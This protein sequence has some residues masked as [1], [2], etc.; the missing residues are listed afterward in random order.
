M[1]YYVEPLSKQVLYLN[2]Y[3][4]VKQGQV[5]CCCFFK[6]QSPFALGKTFF[7]LNPLTIKRKFG[8]TKLE[9][10]AKAV[11]YNMTDS[12]EYVV[13]VCVGDG[14]VGGESRKKCDRWSWKA[15]VS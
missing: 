15:L 6:T 11:L 10:V 12:R 3:Y 14:G 5:L 1:F 2:K 7:F 8:Q 4:F 13:N 9:A